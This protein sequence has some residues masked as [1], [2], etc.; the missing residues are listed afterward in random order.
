MRGILL[1]TGINTANQAN[2]ARPLAKHVMGKAGSGLAI[3]AARG[4]FALSMADF[5]FIF[6]VIDDCKGA[7]AD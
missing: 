3:V 5:R 1:E 4:Y 2:H 6:F 7:A